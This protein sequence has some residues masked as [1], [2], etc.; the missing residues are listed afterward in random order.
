M[1]LITHLL[2]SGNPYCN[3]QLLLMLIFSL[4]LLIVIPLCHVSEFH[5]AFGFEISLF[6][7]C[8]LL[9]FSEF[10]FKCIRENSIFP[11]M[12]PS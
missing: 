7:S 2:T 1:T 9:I 12:E 8:F 6:V 11:I 3:N 4:L 10:S 5:S